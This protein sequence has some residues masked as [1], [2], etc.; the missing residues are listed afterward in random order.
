[1]R[2]DADRLK[3]LRKGRD[4]ARTELA[5]RS[6]VA[7][8]TVQRL[9]NEPEHCQKTREETAPMFGMTAQEARTTAAEVGRAVRGWRDKVARLGIAPREV[10]RM[11]SAFDHD[12]LKAAA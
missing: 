5:K 11:S 9:E 12:D 3:S 2:I 6:G 4:L 8:R 7:T 1:M 10:E